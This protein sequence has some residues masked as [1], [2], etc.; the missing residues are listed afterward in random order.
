MPYT[1]PTPPS[2]RPSSARAR[3]HNRPACSRRFL[4]SRRSTVC[5]T[6]P[7][8]SPGSICVRSRCSALPRTSPTRVS[9]NRSC[10]SPTGR[11]ASTL[12]ECGLSPVAL[13]GHSLGE[14]AALALAEVFSVEAGLELV[15]ERSRLMATTAASTP[16]AMA[17]VLGMEAGAIGRRHRRHRGRVGR[18]RQRARPGRHLGNSWRRR[19]RDGGTLRRR[20]SADRPAAGRGCRSTLRS[21]RQPPTRSRTSSRRRTSRDAKIPVLQNTDPQPT[22]DAELIRQR[23]IGQIVS[24]VRWT[25]TMRQLSADGPVTLIECGPGHGPHRTRETRRRR[26]GDLCVRVRHRI[27]TSGGLMSSLA[28]KVALVTGASSGI[29]AA[30]AQRLA[31]DGAVVAVNCYP[32]TEADARGRRCSDRDSRAAAPPS[33]RRTS[34]TPSSARA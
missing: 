31:A 29:G 24:P 22:T 6:P 8:R 1:S 3:A 28:G 11:G 23:L 4:S 25:E 19:D 27:D 34:P 17:A 32:G 15:V 20:R 33:S 18:E 7:R 14:F 9:R 2:E 21:W 30:I 13:A 26:D 5:S 16:G 12:L 10:I